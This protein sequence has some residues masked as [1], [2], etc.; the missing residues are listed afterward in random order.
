M[1]QVNDCLVHRHAKTFAYLVQQMQ[2]N[3]GAQSLVVL[4]EYIGTS[5]IPSARKLL[6]NL[7]RNLKLH[8]RVKSPHILELDIA[9]RLTRMDM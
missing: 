1:Y 9:G 4:K 8:M 5:N 7:L 3:S 2:T 6:V